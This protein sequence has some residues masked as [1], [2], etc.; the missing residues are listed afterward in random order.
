VDIP[1]SPPDSYSAGKLAT[2]PPLQAQA[3][4]NTVYRLNRLRAHADSLQ[5]RPQILHMTVDSAIR[6][7]PVVLINVIEQLRP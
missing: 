5:L 7:Y 6:Y 3:V 2:V 1:G 4:P